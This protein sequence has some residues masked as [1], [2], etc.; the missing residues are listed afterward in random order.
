VNSD[1][2]LDADVQEMLEETPK[3][4]PYVSIIDMPEASRITSALA[5][6]TLVKE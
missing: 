6:T 3:K 5:A 2:R 1:Q 4:M